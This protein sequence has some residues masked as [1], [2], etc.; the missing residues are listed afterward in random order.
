MRTWITGA[1]AVIAAGMHTVAPPAAADAKPRFT[2]RCQAALTDDAPA[3]FAAELDAVDRAIEGGRL[4]AARERHGQAA[5]RLPRTA[6]VSVHVKCVG[7]DLY[8]RWYAQRAAIG[9]LLAEARPDDWNARLAGVIGRVQEGDQLSADAIAAVVPVTPTDYAAA[10]GR[11][12]WL[13]ETVD[14][15]R[16]HDRYV[17]DAERA[18]AR[19]GDAGA[20]ELLHRAKAR[21]HAML[22]AE[23]RAFAGE[24][25][26][27]ESALTEGMAGADAMMSAVAGV[28]PLAGRAQTR[29]ALARGARSLDMLGETARWAAIAGERPQAGVRARAKD[30]GD[31]F[32]AGGDEERY[33]FAVRDDHYAMAI[34]FYERAGDRADEELRATLRAR[35]SIQDDLTSETEA[36][37]AA[38]ASARERL[39]QSAEEARQAAEDMEKSDAEKEAFDAE[40]DDEFGDMEDFFEE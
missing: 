7:E 40:F 39:E 3:W 37:E 32:R 24:D 6:D 14:D 31:A 8:A 25:P 18:A 20:E 13:R 10:I 2:E 26:E 9:R 4:E 29:A 22:D 27:L 21:V 19:A 1:A 33:G 17:L 16:E 35:A 34:D 15:D 30:R 11:L 38:I 5:S 23:A 36:R 12:R 28:E